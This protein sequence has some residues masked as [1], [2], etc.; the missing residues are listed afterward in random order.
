MRMLPA[1]FVTALT[2]KPSMPK[3]CRT[4]F[5]VCG[6]S[7]LTGGISL[8]SATFQLSADM[9]LLPGER[10]RGQESS[11][12]SLRCQFAVERRKAMRDDLVPGRPFP[13]LRLPEHTG[14]E[15][16]L[17]EIAEGQPLVLCFV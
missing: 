2:P 14:K 1:S 5:H 3:W 10:G 4:D 15:L 6:Q 16:S 7:S 12:P 8:T 11:A 9:V 17:S 13:D